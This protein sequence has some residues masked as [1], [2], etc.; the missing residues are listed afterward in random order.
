[1]FETNLQRFILNHYEILNVT[2]QCLKPTYNR[3]KR[4]IILTKNVTEQCLKPTYNSNKYPIPIAN[5]V[6]EQC[7]KPTYNT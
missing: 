4:R 5:N 3:W 2:E 6:T 7:L 1:M